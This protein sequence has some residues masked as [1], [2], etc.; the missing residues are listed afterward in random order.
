MAVSN[1]QVSLGELVR[2]AFPRGVGGLTAAARERE[3][4]W[5]VVAGS[6]VAP[7]AGDVVLCASLPARKELAA[8]TERG[9]TAVVVASEEAAGKA[10][11]PILTLPPGASLR[12]IQHSALELI[13]NRQSYLINRGGQIYQV[14][15]RLSVEGVGLL[16]LAQAMSEQTGKA[17]LVQDKRLQPL[18]EAVPPGLAEHWPEAL[19]ALRSWSHLPETLRDR[20]QAAVGGW[21]DQSLASGLTRL[22]CPIVAKG[23]ARGYL[24]VV[25]RPGEVD[26]LDQLVVE[27]GAAACALEMAKAKAVSDAEKRAHGD[28]LD[29]VL[30]GSVPLDELVHWAQR[31]GYDVEPPHA[32]Q[33]WRWAQDDDGQDGE[34]APP[35]DPDQPVGSQ[36]GAERADPAAQ[37]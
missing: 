2:L 16:G 27:H 33:I 6:G 5:V 22:V 18:A 14:L 20:R 1:F 25:G 7:Q 35:G 8:W 3:A 19:E 12:D 4:R 10:D 31:I 11:L 34:R 36:A 17:V 24:S 26:A 32:A 21:R 9:V 23:M 15:A 37:Q 13:V 29:A 28:F 30:T